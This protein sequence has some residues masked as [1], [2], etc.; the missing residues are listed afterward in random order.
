MIQFITDFKNFIWLSFSHFIVS[1]RNPQFAFNANESF[2]VTARWVQQFKR[3][4]NAKLFSIVVPI[5]D[6]SD[7][8]IIKVIYYGNK[9]VRMLWVHKLWLFYFLFGHAPK[10]QSLTLKYVHPY[11]SLAFQARGVRECAVCVCVFGLKIAEIIVNI[12]L[13]IGPGDS[14]TA[15]IDDRIW[16]WNEPIQDDDF[17]M[18]S[19][20]VVVIG[21]THAVSSFI[22][23]T[24]CPVLGVE[25]SSNLVHAKSRDDWSVTILSGLIVISSHTYLKQEDLN[26]IEFISLCG[27]ISIN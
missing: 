20:S 23:I 16:L 18:P 10:Y 15:L 13:V 25:L 14:V 7:Q 22:L 3:R 11:L 19:D 27:N 8:F 5:T 12:Y 6:H 1:Y 4:A 26:G 2:K 24:T 17:F 9:N 21:D